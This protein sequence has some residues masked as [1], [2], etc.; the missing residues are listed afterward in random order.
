[1]IRKLLLI[2]AAASIPMGALAVGAVGGGVAA[3][4]TPVTCSIAS[5]TTFNAPGLSGGGVATANKTSTTTTSTGTLAGLGCTG[6]VPA[7]SIPSKNGKCKVTS[8]PAVPACSKTL[9]YVED[10]TA[11]FAG[12]G[13]SSI[14][15]T[16][17]AFHFTINSVAYVGKATTSKA[18]VSCPGELGFTVTGSLKTGGYTAFTLNACLGTDTGS[19]LASGGASFSVDL[20]AATSTPTEVIATA[21]IDP[22]LSTLSIH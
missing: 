17:K 14:L 19:N 7:L 12:T 1:M 13:A 4:A 21:A 18:S 16:L 2:G 10:S 8:P 6:S 11:G 20:G 5:T 15:K 3:A 22:T 9:K